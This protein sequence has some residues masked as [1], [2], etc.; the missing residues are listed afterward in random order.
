MLFL[1]VVTLTT[2]SFCDIFINELMADNIST[3]A[4]DNSDYDDWVELYNDTDKDIDLGGMYLTDNL[5]NPTKWQFPNLTK[6]KSKKYSIL[7]IITGMILR[8]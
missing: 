4:D 3:I 2:H 6:I 8:L 5:L 1:V 7:S